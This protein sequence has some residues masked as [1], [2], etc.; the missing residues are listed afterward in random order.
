MLLLLN[1]TLLLTILAAALPSAKRGLVF[2]PNPNWP[3]DSSIWIQPGSDLTWYYNYR[4]LPAEE[5]SHLPQSDF[6]F[7]PM[8]WGAGPNPSTD[9]SFANSVVKLIHKGINITHVLTFNEPDAPASWGGSNIS[10]ENAT[11]AWAANILSLQKYG[12]KAGLPAVSGTPG[13]LAWL[14]QFVGNCTL[15][16]GRRF[17][18]DFL[19]VHWYDN[20]DGLR[21]YVS[22]VMVK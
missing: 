12:I 2:I 14:L 18:Y 5:Y 9:S 16:L 3:Q 17:T 4:S 1:A 11:H 8:M 15:V 6:E 13:G 21:R 19:P 10:P 20:F 7:V 22:E